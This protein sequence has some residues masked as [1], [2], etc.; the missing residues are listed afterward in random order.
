MPG[1]A[2]RACQA[3]AQRGAP[4]Q[5]TKAPRAARQPDARQE[6]RSGAAP[7]PKAQPAEGSARRAPGEANSGRRAAAARP[8]GTPRAGVPPRPEPHTAHR[9]ALRRCAPR[10]PLHG[11][12][13]RDGSP[14]PELCPQPAAPY[15]QRSVRPGAT[16]GD[17]ASG[18]ERPP[19]G[20]GAERRDPAGRISPRG[21]RGRR[22]AGWRRR[23]PPEGLPG[24]P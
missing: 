7:R 11:E 17:A 13:R 18:P 19:R 9:T 10:P 12:G 20:C 16:N 21:R 22:G 1:A 23:R 2:G 15:P 8:E 24:S 4:R 14:R 3:A 5:P 6:P